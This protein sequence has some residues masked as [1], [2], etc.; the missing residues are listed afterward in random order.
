MTLF[1]KLS[2]VSSNHFYVF[3]CYCIYLFEPPGIYCDVR[4]KVRIQLYF[5]LDGEHVAP[6]SLIE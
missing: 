5:F 6:T 2:Q 1:K 4:D 3:I